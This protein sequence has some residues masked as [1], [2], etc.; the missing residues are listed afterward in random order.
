HTNATLL[1]EGGVDFKTLQNRL[2]H[3]LIGTTMDIYAHV[4]EDMNRNATCVIE[5]ILKI[6]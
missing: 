2:G 6:K 5:N 1:L 4:T 3:S